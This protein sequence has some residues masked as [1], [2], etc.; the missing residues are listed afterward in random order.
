MLRTGEGLASTPRQASVAEYVG[1]VAHGHSVTHLDALSHMFW[2][3]KMYN[4]EPAHAVT[5][6][7][8]ACKHAVTSARQGIVTRGVLVDVPRHRDVRWLE[9][10]ESVEASEVAQIL[11][12]CGIEPESGDAVLLRTGY[13][14]KRVEVGPD[15]FDEGRPGWGV[16][17]LPWFHDAGIALIGSDTAQEVIPSRYAQMPLPIHAVGITAMG[18]WLLDNCDLE[19]LS[20]VCAEHATWEFQFVVAPLPL[21][22]A[23]GSPVNPLA[24][25]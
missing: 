20:V 7:G 10:G 14:R 8:G 3:R 18:L 6:G 17:C 4:G 23:T 19:T 1:I 21:A 16:S 13:G 25:L 9:A 2:D 24:V 5:A 22:G 11:V 15:R 12:A